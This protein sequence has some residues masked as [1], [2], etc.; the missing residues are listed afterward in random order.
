DFVKRGSCLREYAHAVAGGREPTENHPT[1]RFVILEDEDARTR[2]R[3][4][5]LLV[6][7]VHRR[8]PGPPRPAVGPAAPN[9]GPCFPQEHIQATV[10]ARAVAMLSIRAPS[11]W[12]P[13]GMTSPGSAGEPACG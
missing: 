2:G 3:R 1:H 9:Q 6:C 11:P 10:S 13:S 8:P 4:P 5:G 7:R 12:F